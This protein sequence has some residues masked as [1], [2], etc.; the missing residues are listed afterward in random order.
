GRRWWVVGGG[1]ADRALRGPQ[2]SPCRTP[3]QIHRR[4]VQVARRVL[5]LRDPVPPLPDPEE[6]FLLEI[7]SFVAASGEEPQGTEEPG[8]FPFVERLEG[9]GHNGRL[10]HG[11]PGHGGG[12]IIHPYHERPVRPFL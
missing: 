7:L 9:H 5:H 6:R 4:A 2:R 3:V 1:Q 10:G 12:R 8:G 11:H